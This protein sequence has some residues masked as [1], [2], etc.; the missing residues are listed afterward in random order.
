M[1][2]SERRRWRD[3]WRA[4]VCELA[5]GTAW[6]DLAR[7]VPARPTL[8]LTA[9]NPRGRRLPEAINAARDAVLRAEL[10][11]LGYEARRARGSSPARDWHEDGWAIEHRD[12]R[13]AEL[14]RGYGQLAA[15]VYDRGGRALLWAD[16]G[17]DWLE[18]PP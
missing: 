10:H 16:G 7:A 17:L 12:E 3:T 4:T 14:V 11:A 1:D 2:E 15:F 6:L 13:S 8:V 18:P 5:D 9:W